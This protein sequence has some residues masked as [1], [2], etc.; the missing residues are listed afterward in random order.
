MK[1]NEIMK[2]LLDVTHPGKGD[3]N[4]VELGLVESVEIQGND[5]CVTLAFP[6]HW[7]PLAE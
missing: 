1:Q 3:R 5:V 2:M 7:D 6:K 4:I